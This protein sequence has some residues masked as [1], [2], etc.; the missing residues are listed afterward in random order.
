MITMKSFEYDLRYLNAGLEI[1]EKYLL[2]DEV[3]WSID[4]NPPEG[5]PAYP[6]LTLDGLLLAQARL[7]GHRLYPNHRGQVDSIMANLEFDRS[8]WRVAW[9]KKAGQCYFVRERMWRGFLQEYQ[10]N[11]QENADR[12]RYEVRL[13]VMLELSQSELGR[14]DSV[15]VDS[16]PGLDV[17]L[18]GVLVP[19]GFIWDP[20][21]MGGFPED[22]YWFLYGEL[23]PR[24]S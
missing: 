15:D 1:L 3:F 18:K 4:V 20:D 23:P 7:A 9:E 13:R 10:D 5:E 19:N 24:K 11:P 12:Y 17:Y 22:V 6:K 8:K 2:S 16:L 14:K 21:I